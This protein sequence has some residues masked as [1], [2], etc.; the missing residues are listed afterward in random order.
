MSYAVTS[1][2]EFVDDGDGKYCVSV[3]VSEPY[4]DDGHTSLNFDNVFISKVGSR[5]HADSSEHTC[6]GHKYRGGDSD[7]PDWLDDEIIEEFERRV[8]LGKLKPLQ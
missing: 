2:W 7:Y 4:D 3:S 8:K 5:Y 1:N 6:D